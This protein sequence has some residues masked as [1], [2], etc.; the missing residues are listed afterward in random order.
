MA[1]T[2]PF[3]AAPFL[4]LLAL[5]WPAQA[6]EA[7]PLSLQQLVHRV[8]TEGPQIQAARLQRD[9]AATG[10]ERAQG[11]FQPMLSATVTN[12]YSSQTNT[13]E[14]FLAR[15]RTLDY[16]R[17]GI[18]SSLGISQLL[19]TGTRLEAKL[20]TSR[21]DSSINQ[22]QTENSPDLRPPGSRDHRSLWSLNLV[23]P[24]AR[25][26]GTAVTQARVEVARLEAE[27]GGKDLQRTQ[28]TALADALVAYYELAL[29]GERLKVAEAKIAMGERLLRDA[30]ALLA[31]GRLPEADVWEVESALARYRAERSSAQQGER[32]KGNRL[33]SLLMV[34]VAEQAGPW[35][36]ADPLP[37]VGALG[38]SPVQARA[39]ALER[40]ED[41]QRQRLN[42]Q[43]EGVQLM[44]AHNQNKPKVDLIASYGRGDLALGW[45]DS[46]SAMRSPT[47]SVGVQAQMPL[48]PNR[49]GQADIAAA[50]VRQRDAELKLKSLEVDISNEVDTAF[51]LVQSAMQRHAD[52]AEIARRETQALQLERQRLAAGRSGMREVLNREERAL[53]AQLGW[54]EQRVAVAQ[55][56]VLLASV[57]GVLEDQWR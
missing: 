49:Q 35:R 3:Q 56:R 44:Y 10:I 20:S 8:R 32:E 57:Q 21:F 24:L 52:W 40:R 53:N 42:S 31:Q 33:K 30:R 36:A 14:E 16:W 55:A 11:A 2:P 4:V 34:S 7:T 37:E 12:G 23:Q 38:L 45:R 5:A 17:K 19:G 6:Q 29:A 41:L 9:L 15:S 39:T 18:D 27:A 50:Q 47:W 1:T 13:Y 51:G 28:T 48:G 46:L 54:T 22:L 43:R 25:D 26:A